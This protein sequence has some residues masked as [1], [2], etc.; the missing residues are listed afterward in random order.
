VSFRLSVRSPIRTEQLGPHWTKFHEF[1]YWSFFRNYAEKIK[2]SLKYDK[3]NGYLL[4]D[5]YALLTVSQWILLRIRSVSEKVA[6]KIKEHILYSITL[7]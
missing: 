2:V 4:G 7:L 1:S 3:N 6:V 5:Q